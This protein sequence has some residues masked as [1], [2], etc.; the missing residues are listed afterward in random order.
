MDLHTAC[1]ARGK[2]LVAVHQ[3][4][5]YPGA[6]AC[7]DS[8]LQGVPYVRVTRIFA[9]EQNEAGI[10]DIIL[11]HLHCQE[12]QTVIDL[13]ALFN[14]H[15][16]VVH[17]EP[18]FA[19]ANHTVPDDPYFPKQWGLSAII[20]PKAW[21]RIT[22]CGEVVVGIV[23]SGIDAA[24]PDLVQNMWVSPAGTHGWNFLDEND[25]THDI[26]GH[27]THVAGIIGGVGNNALGISG[28]CWQVKLAA[29]KIGDSSFGLSAAIA[30]I[31]Y[32]NA[33]EIM[34]LNSSWGGRYNSPILEHAISQYRGLFVVSAGNVGANN[35]IT[36][37]FP[38]NF[39]CENIINVAACDA[40]G[41]LAPFSN[42]GVNNV[43]IAAPGV[44][45]LSTVLNDDYDTRSGSSMSAPFVAGA[46]ALLKAQ[47]P[48]MDA[49]ALKQ[50]ILSTASPRAQMAG[51]TKT[52]AVL[53]AYAMLGV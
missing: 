2:V 18:C 3:A 38:G 35:D 39:A 22:G 46:A 5:P 20:T 41:N 33:H 19:F 32:A 48:G 12:K 27:G 8:I 53:D 36:P 26:T 9:S 30:A 42:Y 17:A 15:P 28:V 21:E 10:G 51:K 44:D 14:R 40:S 23:D 4:H 11:V 50:R 6:Q 49:L 16:Y 45:I 52:G 37:D 29:L 31:H 34:V 13:V 7:Y 47:S 1:F 25:D 43:D 24:H